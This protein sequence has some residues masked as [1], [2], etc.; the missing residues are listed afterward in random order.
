[1]RVVVA[2]DDMLTREGIIRLL[3]DAGVHVVEPPRTPTRS[4]VWSQSM[5]PDAAIVDIRMPPTY[6]DEGL[7]AARRIRTE[8][9]RTGVLVL[10]QYVEP[11][12]AIRLLDEHPERV[13]YL[14]KERVFD[15][16]VLLD[17]LRRIVTARLSSTPRSSPGC[18]GDPAAVT[19]STTLTVREREV[20]S[21]VAEGRSNRG[22]ADG[23]SS[24]N[25]PS[26]RTSS[27]SSSSSSLDS[28]T[29]TPTA[30]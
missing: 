3:G 7:V 26:R 30:A 5:P 24:P 2:D 20:L 6:S 1:M 10:S 12:Y 4:C 15:V 16:V 14:L 29:T 11:S 18:S 9:P 28:G 27:G 21:L 23:S 17:A 19:R 25:A 8:Y 22:I 13:G